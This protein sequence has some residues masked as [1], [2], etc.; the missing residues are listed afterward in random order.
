MDHEGQPA[1][2][3]SGIK[4]STYFALLIRPNF[5]NNNPLLRELYQLAQTIDL[6]RLGRLAETGA[7]VVSSGKGSG[8]HK[9]K[10]W[11]GSWWLGERWRRGER[12]GQRAERKRKRQGKERKRRKERLEQRYQGGRG[13]PLEGE[14]GDSREEGLRWGPSSTNE[15]AE[16]G[17][18]SELVDGLNLAWAVLWR[19]NIAYDRGWLGFDWYN[20]AWWLG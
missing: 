5:P 7:G 16:D 19:P 3:T 12:M 20:P 11:A 4:L 6:L 15:K 18:R 10:L 9:Q 13:E 14:Q 8:I 1:S 2:L 17:L